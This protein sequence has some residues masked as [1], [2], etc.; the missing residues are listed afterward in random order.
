[1]FLN[2]YSPVLQRDILVFIDKLSST[3]EGCNSTDFLIVCGDFNCT[4]SDLDRNHIEPHLQS[5]RILKRIVESYDLED[6][7]R[8]KHST[9]RELSWF[10]C[11]DKYLSLAR[12]DRFYCYGHHIPFFKS[13]FMSPVGFS[14]HFMVIGTVFISGV[15]PKSA[16][17]HFNTDL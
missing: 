17:W 9:E 12:L 2:I 3:L 4:I 11:R 7:W 13:C 15:K 16:Y 8:S 1:M 14:D 6:V 10:H 5:R